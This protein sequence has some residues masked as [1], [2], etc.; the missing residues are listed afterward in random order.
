MFTRREY[1]MTPGPT[2]IPER[3]I[4]AITSKEA[5]LPMYDKIYGEDLRLVMKLT[6]SD[7]KAVIMGGGATVGLESALSSLIGDYDKVLVLSAGFFGDILSN[8]VK[9]YSKKVN[10]LRAKVGSTVSDEDTKKFLKENPDA[11][12]VVLTHCE[13]STGA[14][15]N[16]ESLSETIRSY[17]NALIIVDCVSTIGA[18]P[19]SIRKGHADVLIFGVQKVL[20]MPPGLAIIALGKNALDILERR[21]GRSYYMNLKTWISCWEERGYLPSTPPVNLLYGLREA[22]NILFEEG[23]ENV[24]KRH[25]KV[26]NALR[27]YL[28]KLGL[29][30]VVKDHNIASPTV[31]A[32]HVPAKISDK[33]FTDRL[34][35]DFRVLIARTYGELRGKA[36]RIGHMG[37]SATLD[38][39]Y[40]TLIAIASTLRKMG[41]Q[42]SKHVFQNLLL[43]VS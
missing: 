3:I 42:I 11:K 24:F 17:S 27:N 19:I 13:T 5:L 8:M 34:W 22:I 41:V 33:E 35:S 21:E 18:I 9:L 28:E 37:S 7:G 32:F 26:S 29:E 31:T 43:N 16:L 2:P 38:N 30:L 25:E 15:F 36:V 40:V 10:I 14:L 39:I 1:I 4:K 6:D 20:N 23:L 12:F